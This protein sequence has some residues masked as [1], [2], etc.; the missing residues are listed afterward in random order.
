MNVEVN[1][2]QH[3]GRDDQAAAQQARRVFRS[4]CVMLADTSAAVVG[5]VD[6][7]VPLSG[8]PG[9]ASRFLRV[10][11][12]LA[13]EYRLRTTSSLADGVLEVRF[14]RRTPDSDRGGVRL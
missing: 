14:S 10:A 1:R 11:K 6:V 2:E 3:A 7:T 13:E 4:A 9:S 8:E 12:G 5:A